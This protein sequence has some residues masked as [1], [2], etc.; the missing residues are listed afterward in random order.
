LSNKTS[1]TPLSLTYGK[2]ALDIISSIHYYT[3]R[4]VY[5][6]TERG[7]CSMCPS[8]N[9]REVILDAAQAVVLEVG[10][11][12]MTLDAVAKKAGVSKGGLLYHF[13]TKEALLKELLKRRLQHLEEARKRKCAELQEGP[14]RE[15]KAYVLSTLA[16]G[17]KD[18]PIGAA[19]LA[20]IA[21]DPKLLEPVRD[22]YLRRLAELIP[23][24]LRFE[25]AVI[26]A[27][28][29]DGLRLLELLS[30]S[31]LNDRQ[32]KQVIEEL[33]RLADEAIQKCG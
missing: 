29:A 3:V 31:P 25:R 16:R 8:Q 4:T 9:S 22:D 19:L 6:K 18:G 24:G 21:H 33:L 14:T 28:A 12:H 17:R 32:R 13:P 20:A 23:V 26:V 1:L 10:A 5:I 27:L 2:K 7:V 30:L 11:A 15:I